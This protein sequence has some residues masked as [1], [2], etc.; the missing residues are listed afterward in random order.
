MEQRTG[1]GVGNRNN[2]NMGR[3]FASAAQDQLDELRGQFGEVTEQVSN[4]VRERPGTALLIAV[5]AGFLIGRM[6][7]S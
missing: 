6:L 1:G 2:G 7:R 4:F 5:G 3:E